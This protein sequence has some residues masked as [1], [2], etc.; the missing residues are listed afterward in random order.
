MDHQDLTQDQMDILSRAFDSDT[1]S[2]RIRLRKGEYQFELAK[3][4]ASQELQLKLPNAKDLVKRLYSEEKEQ[5]TRFMNKIQTILKK[6]EKSGVVQILPKNKPWELQKYALL[7][8]KF[9]DVENNLIVLAT[10]D[11]IKQAQSLLRTKP[12]EQ[13]IPTTEQS[14]IKIKILTL[15]LIAILSYALIMWTL[16]QPT[17][18]TIVLTVAFFG[19]SVCSLLVGL[20]LARR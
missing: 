11:Q 19:A 13:S 12:A 7:S 1:R 9:Q 8:F 16:A 5:D 2:I 18:N 4:I 15:V 3:E 10:D 14:L 17:V 20:L 6:M